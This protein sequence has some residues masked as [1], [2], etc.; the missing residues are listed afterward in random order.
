MKLLITGACGLIGRKLQDE[1]GDSH[2]LRL[3]DRVKP[4]DATLF[5]GGRDRTPAPFEPQWPFFQGEITDPEA[6]KPAIEGVEA[7]VHLAAQVAG[8]P[9]IGIETFRDNALGTFIM[10]DLARQAGV[11]RFLCASSINAFGTFYWRI[12]GKP[13]DWGPLPLTED[14]D[15][16]PE[17][18]YSLSKLVNEHTCAAFDRGYG[19]TTAAFRF[20]GVHGQES[21][22][23]FMQGLQPTTEWSPT[24]WQWAHVGDIARGLRQALECPT[25]PGHGVYTLAAADTCAPEPTME[26]LE[27]FR[28]DL[29]ESVTRPLL[30]RESLLSTDRARAT[31]GYEPQ[32]RMGE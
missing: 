28:P 7:I 27:R 32:Y 17:D 22:E 19:I 25:L 16:V 2:D 24:L 3:F 6:V 21:Y 11:R 9:E 31:F 10:L 29:A 18:P 12:S 26:L 15:P 5:A 30:G 23:A 13:V 20:A 8:H 4:E 1:L 14:F